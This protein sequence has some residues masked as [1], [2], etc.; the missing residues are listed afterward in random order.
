[1]RGEM[2][3]LL[4]PE[5]WPNL[6]VDSDG[7]SADATANDCPVSVDRNGLKPLKINGR[8]KDTGISA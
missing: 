8:K 6:T 4:I 3:I 1:M 7:K 5:V 2:N